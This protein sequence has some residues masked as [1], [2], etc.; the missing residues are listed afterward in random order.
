VRALLDA[1]AAGLNRYAEKHPASRVCQGCSRSTARMSR[2][3]SCCALPSSS[4]SIRCWR[5]WSATRTCGRN[6]ER[7]CPTR[8]MSPRRGRR[9]SRRAPT[10]LRSRHRARRT[11]RP[12]SF[13]TR[14][15]PGPAASPG[16]RRWCIARKAGTLPARYFPARPSRCS[17]TT[18]RSAGP[19][20]STGPT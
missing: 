1:Y 6:G 14:T 17:A 20:P 7:R 18:A 9:R 13:P 4:G 2:P 19:T 3:G 8:R 15:S 16:M 11:G 5:R 12:G 10:P